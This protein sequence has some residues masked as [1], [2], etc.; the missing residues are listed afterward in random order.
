VEERLTALHTGVRSL[1][2]DR[3][4][5]LIQLAEQG[6]ECLSMPD[7]FPVLHELIKRYALPMG[8]R[9][10]QARKPLAAAEPALASRLER[11]PRAPANSQAQAAVEA[12]RTEVQR[13]EEVHSTYRH[14]LEALSLTLHPFTLHDSTPQTSAQGPQRL[15]AA[16]DAIDLLG[17]EQQL[18]AR[19]ATLKKV[20]NQGPALAALVDFWWAGVE[21]D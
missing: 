12:S 6:V 13:W 17:Q 21:Q 3:A 2:S 10:H 20:R 15:H 4:K 18:P 9:L 8:Q 1:V 11:T 16:I 19:H 5:A 14:P 7:F